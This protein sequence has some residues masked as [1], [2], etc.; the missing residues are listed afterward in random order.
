MSISTKNISLAIIC[1][2][3]IVALYFFNKDDGQ[4]IVYE[5]KN[6]GDTKV[7]GENE[8]L[9]KQIAEIDTDG[10]DLKDWEESLWKTDPKNPDSDGDGTN[11]GEETAQNRDPNKKGPDD[12]L[13]PESFN[14]DDGKNGLTATEKL[15]QETLR[16]LVEAKRSGKSLDETAAQD[17]IYEIIE[18][19]KDQFEAKVYA[20]SDILIISDE[21]PAALRE[22]G[23]ALGA[24]HKKNNPVKYEDSVLLLGRAVQEEDPEIPSKL[25]TN[26]EAFAAN[27]KDSLLLPVPKSALV[28][29]LKLINALSR[30]EA[31][32]RSFA[33]IYDDPVMSVVGVSEYKIAV[34]Q[35]AD[36]LKGL[37]EYFAL[38]G[39][40]FEQGESG[41][42]LMNPTQLQKKPQ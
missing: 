29:H 32:V 18:S 16:Q 13:N 5:P 12:T 7:L 11:D 27:V 17:I 19:K 2:G 15:S 26:A 37:R 24:L 8:T 9:A 23:N 31:V 38:R 30:M 35:L 36:A 39:I 1:A 42:Q 20:Q 40:I 21:S 33:K 22:F 25:L 28:V 10:D 6:A 3:I 4:T 41:Y 34:K 14:S